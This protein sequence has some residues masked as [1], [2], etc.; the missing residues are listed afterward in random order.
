MSKDN[1]LHDSLFRETMCEQSVASD[2]LRNY[3]PANVVRHIRLETLSIKKDSFID[4]AQAGVY[5]DLLYEVSLANDEPGFIYFLFEHKSSP[6]K[7]VSLQ[8]L[9]Y[10]LEVWEQYRKEHKGRRVKHLP[11]IIPIVVYH[12]K[13]RQQGKRLGD[14]VKTPHKELASYVPDFALAFHDFSPKSELEI[15]GLIPFPSFNATNK[16][17]GKDL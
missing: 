1:D 17:I 6:Q 9:K 3:L 5:S 4:A 7:F 16:S 13:T 11:L 8:L 2:F 14:L 15:K 12:G 10:M